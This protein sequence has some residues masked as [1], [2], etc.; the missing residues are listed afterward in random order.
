MTAMTKIILMSMA[1]VLMIATAATAMAGD[2][3]KK[4]RNTASKAAADGVQIT[5][6]AIVRAKA[7]VQLP[8]YIPPTTFRPNSQQ[9]N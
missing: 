1:L 9:P 5:S 2:N 7:R 4:E 6:Q 3:D 8:T